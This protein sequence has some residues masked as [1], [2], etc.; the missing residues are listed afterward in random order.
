MVLRVS[1]A[2][3]ISGTYDLYVFDSQSSSF[4]VVLMTGLS[5]NLNVYGLTY[6]NTDFLSQI[7]LPPWS[8]LTSRKLPRCC[9]FF[10]GRRS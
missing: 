7:F 5:G 1:N 10:T 9:L 4:R 3:K 2:D 6:E 8:Q